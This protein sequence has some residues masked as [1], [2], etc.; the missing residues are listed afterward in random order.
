MN[1][2]VK[3]VRITCDVNLYTGNVYSALTIS[4][5]LFSVR[6]F[7]S[8][9][10]LAIS[11]ACLNSQCGRNIWSVNFTSHYI[12]ILLP[13]TECYRLALTI[14]YAIRLVYLYLYTTAYMIVGPNHCARAFSYF[15]FPLKL[16]VCLNL[17]TMGNL[18]Q[19]SQATL[20]DHRYSFSSTGLEPKRTAQLRSTY[21][22]QN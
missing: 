15:L 1:M 20:I 19:L 18:F 17:N 4:I 13:R 21:S 2:L 8:Q 16:Y 10:N 7:I 11:C 6:P 12:P 3:S 5:F 9:Y 14:T 22:K